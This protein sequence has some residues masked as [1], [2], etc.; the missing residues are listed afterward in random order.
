MRRRPALLLIVAL[1]VTGTSCS[2]DGGSGAGDG[3]I[4][5]VASFFPLAELARG[6]GGPDVEVTDLTP[7]GVEPHDLEPSSREVDAIEDADVVLY[8]G[9]GFQPGVERA[10]A[11]ARG[12]R[13]VDLAK[14]LPGAIPDDPHV[15]LD[16][17][18]A[19]E[20]ADRVHR[21]LSDAHEPK[22]DELRSRYES[23]RAR[24]EQLMVAYRTR[25]RTCDRRI[26]VT[27]HDAFGYLARGYELEQHPLTGLTPDA[28]PDPKR[29]AQLADLVRARGVTTVFTE[30]AGSSK[31]AEALAREA[32]V[33]TAVL[34][35]LETPTEGGYLGGM[36]ANLDA[37]ATGMGCR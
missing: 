26:L 2:S 17:G 24:L 14:G 21:A 7:A 34:H 31:S 12:G 16:P 28:E 37:L 32:G 8:V 23:Y 4:R 10:V 30:G 1:A 15:W 29:L 27:T 5:V 25:L 33:G 6:I 11:R 18:M 9:G 3:R 19:L 35:T 36:Q 20:L 13:H 22:R